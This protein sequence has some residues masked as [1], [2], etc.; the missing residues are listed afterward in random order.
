MPDM[1]VRLDCDVLQADGGTRTAAIT[2][3][4]VALVCA[5]RR[6]QKRGLLKRF[7]L[8]GSVAA[9]SGGIVNGVPV[10]DLDYHEDSSAA[11]DANFVLTGCG[12]LVEIQATAEQTAFTR[13]EFTALLDLAEEGIRQLTH[14]Q[15]QVLEQHDYAP[16]QAP[17]QNSARSAP[18]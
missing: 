4:W 10:L 9:V 12:Q 3:A 17:V 11:T 14:R 7:P 15:T 13:P 2:G 5:L 18:V 1:Q 16:A 8:T 6:V